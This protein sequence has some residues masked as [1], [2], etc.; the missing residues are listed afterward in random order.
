VST[1]RSLPRTRQAII[2]GILLAAL[3]ACWFAYAP[4]ITGSLQFDDR[5]SLEGLADVQDASSAL[6]YVVAGRAGPLGRP[7]SLV[8]F[9]PQAYA[10]P[11]SPDVLLRTNILIHLLNGVLVAWLLYA[12]GL[13]RRQTDEQAAAVGV[14]SGAIWMF[15]PIL[16][17]SSMM[18]VQRMT[19]LSA[20]FVLMGGI[21]YLYARRALERRP[22][23]ALAGMTFA[24]GCGA[25]LAALAKENGILLVLFIL[26]TESTLL[27]RPERISRAAWHAWF[28]VVFFVPCAVLV[29]FLATQLPYSEEVVLHRGFT[30]FERLVTQAEVLWK[31]LFLSFLPSVP[32]LVPF[33]DDYQVQRSLMN[34]V[35]LL[36]VASWIV[37]I[38][39]AAMTRRRYPLFGFAVAWYLAGHLLE[40]SSIP[41]ELYFEHRNYVPLIG[42]IYALMASI[43]YSGA[44]LRRLAVIATAGYCLV[45]GGV[46]YSVTSLWGNPSIAAEMWSI[47][48][49]G[50]IRAAEKLAVELELK[51]D[52]QVARKVLLDVLEYNPEALFLDFR[53]F[54]IQCQR[55]DDVD[56]T[57]TVRSY[58]AKLKSTSFSYASIGLL[59]MSHF[60]AQREECSLDAAAVHRLGNSLM[61]NPL[62]RAPAIQHDIHM[63]LARAALDNRDL[64]LGVTHIEQALRLYQVPWGLRLSGDILDGLGPP[65]AFARVIA[66]A[67]RRKPAHPFRAMLWQEQIDR[68]VD[69]ERRARN[70]WAS[71]Q[72]A[73]VR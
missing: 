6:R 55:E 63:V 26:A 48:R 46:L 67:R 5:A 69:L 39:A 65:E 71:T 2:A 45:L 50:S 32:A 22:V 73:G 27:R 72:G 11:D 15:L 3:V 43:L 21:A 44:K 41:L 31:Y 64:E 8:T 28:S 19:T 14:A 23:P 56:H 47:Y 42:P 12:L 33:H 58:E 53:A 51:G 52:P 16:A 10:W 17:S 59:T 30:G 18:V 34:P 29:A 9:A 7:I 40:S 66:E 36:A 4:G 1:L 13:A 70:G 25:T 20:S 54:L 37:A 35:A 60:L 57:D 49:P 68:L 38:A 62:Y 61:Q 24:L